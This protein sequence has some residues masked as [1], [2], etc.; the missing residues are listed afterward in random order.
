MYY[1]ALALEANRDFDVVLIDPCPTAT[2]TIHDLI[3]R[4]PPIVTL[5]QTIGNSASIYWNSAIVS[6]TGTIACGN[7]VETTWDVTSG[8]ELPLD[9]GIFTLS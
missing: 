6:T 3:L 4:T 9:A 1:D 8:S 5:Q 2:L 7:L